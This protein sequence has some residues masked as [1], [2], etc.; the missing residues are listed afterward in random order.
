MT[1]AVGTGWAPEP[2]VAVQRATWDGLR[3]RKARRP[4]TTAPRGVPVPSRR[5]GQPSLIGGLPP[6][7]VGEV[8]T[9]RLPALGAVAH[10]ISDELTDQ[11]ADQFGII[12]VR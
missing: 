5:A 4:E 1:A 8:V 11:I 6:P 9:A 7:L 12:G 2:W 10:D 3:K